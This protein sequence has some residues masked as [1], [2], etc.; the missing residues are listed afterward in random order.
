MERVPLCRTRRKL[1][2]NFRRR[3]V[4]RPVR[5]GL[6][7]MPLASLNLT[8]PAVLRLQ[9]QQQRLRQEELSSLLMGKRGRLGRQR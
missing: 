3:I 8:R 7:S 4:K 1:Q 2:S 6:D 5:N 9:H